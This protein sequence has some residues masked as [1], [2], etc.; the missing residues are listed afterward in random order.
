MALEMKTLQRG[1]LEKLIKRGKPV[2]I[3]VICAIMNWPIKKFKNK[4]GIPAVFRVDQNGREDFR[5]IFP[6]S[7]CNHFFNAPLQIKMEP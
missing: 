3:E 1:L 5:T 2:E 6:D 7:L 4:H